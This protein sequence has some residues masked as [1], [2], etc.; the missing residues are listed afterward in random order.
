MSALL[1][2]ESKPR[3]ALDLALKGSLL[4]SSS[5]L[6]ELNRV[7]S[8]ERFRPYIEEEDTRRFIAALADQADLIEVNVAISACRDP[9]DN[10]L[11]ELA[12][13]GRASHIVTGDSDLLVLDPFQSIRILSPSRFLELGEG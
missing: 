6:V 10:K 3:L 2:P 12:V 7:L 1:L 13:S 8:R 11:L 9:K 5:V 4:L